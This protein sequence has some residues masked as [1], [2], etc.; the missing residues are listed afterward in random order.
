MARHD[1]VWISHPDDPDSPPVSVPRSTFEGSY[2]LNGWVETDA[3]A[4]LGEEASA[5]VAGSA[6]VAVNPSPADA[7]P[8]LKED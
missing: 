2:S 8:P 7:H 5:D 1:R 3:P 4:E 6:T